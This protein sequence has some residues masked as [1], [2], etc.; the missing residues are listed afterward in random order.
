MNTYAITKDDICIFFGGISQRI[1]AVIIFH[2][3]DVCMSV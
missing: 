2:P 3:A 1:T